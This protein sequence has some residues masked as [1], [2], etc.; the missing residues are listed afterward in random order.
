[1]AF[2]G[3]CIIS[4]IILT[5]NLIVAKEMDPIE[6][7]ISEIKLLKIDGKKISSIVEKKGGWDSR[8]FLANE[9]F[10]IKVPRYHQSISSLK[11]ERL[12][13]QLIKGEL[14]LK[15]PDI[16]FAPIDSKKSG[17][18]EINYYEMIKGNELS[19]EDVGSDSFHTIPVRLGIFLSELHN[20]S[21]EIRHLLEITTG[22]FDNGR[23]E[24]DITLWRSVLEYFESQRNS[25]NVPGYIQIIEEAISKLSKMNDEKVPSHADFMS[26]NII[27]QRSEKGSIGIIDWGDFSFRNRIYDFA[28]LYYEYGINFL[29]NMLM[30][31]SV[32][33]SSSFREE[34]RYLSSLVP[35]NT[36][37]FSRN[38]RRKVKFGKDFIELYLDS[39]GRA[40]RMNLIK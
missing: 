39:T 30:G 22:E 9:N 19:P 29:D 14:S 34:V 40:E 18:I 21:G 10:I 31:Y 37:Y 32:Q 33:N 20:I 27:F 2:S 6:I 28:G 11:K 7:D 13:C 16:K 26:N 25:E 1:M 12:V 24:G 3:K 35:F 38:L 17:E 15:I 5:H 8:V 4:N 36:V 23:G